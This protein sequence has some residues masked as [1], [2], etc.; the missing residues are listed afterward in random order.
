MIKEK[1]DPIRVLSFAE[2]HCLIN[3][4]RTSR[5]IATELIFRLRFYIVHPFCCIDKLNYHSLELFVFLVSLTQEN[6]LICDFVWLI[7]FDW[8]AALDY[9]CKS[10]FDQYECSYS[11]WLVCMIIRMTNWINAL[12]APQKNDKNSFWCF[13]KFL[14]LCNFFTDSLE[15]MEM[16]VFTL[17]REI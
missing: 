6:V 1:R 8:L 16:V 11:G 17:V 4:I 13:F 10:Y 12:W 3:K 5:R 14:I 7:L 9:D 2:E 15:W